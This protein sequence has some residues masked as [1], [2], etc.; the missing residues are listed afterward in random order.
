MADVIE[1]KN[2]TPVAYMI[3]ESTVPPDAVSCDIIKKD[4]DWLVAEA[5]LQ[6]AEVLNRNRR[7]Y[8]TEDLHRE[9]YGDRIK[10]LVTTGNMKGEAGHPL[11]MN[12]ARQQKIDPMLEQVWY[13]KLWMEGPVVKSWVRG[14]NNELGKSFNE[15]LKSGQKPSFS[16]RSLGSIQIVNG[17]SKVGN[18]RIV[19]WDRVYFPSYVQAYTQGITESTTGIKTLQESII[20]KGN[21][22]F[23]GEDDNFIAP[24]MNEDV[25][26]M[27]LKESADVYTICNDFSPFYQSIKVNQEGTQV[28]M[29]TDDYQTI[30]VP[31][32]K[33]VQNQINNFCKKF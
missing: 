5:V 28:T 23:V 21:N 27:I 1:F 29:I 12:L 26:K 17:R 7:Y 11:D 19:C 4:K 32:N 14:T 22:L 9:I 10:E 3:N 20:E 15:D 6:V 13:Q 16:L 25:V 30:I 24:I 18:L 33:F 31:L 2:D 8:A